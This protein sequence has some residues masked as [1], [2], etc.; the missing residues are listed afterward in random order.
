[1]NLGKSRD[2]QPL[3]KHNR[4]IMKEQRLVHTFLTSGVEEDE[5]PR[6]HSIFLYI[7]IFSGIW[8]DSP[9]YRYNVIKL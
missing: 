6:V 3:S 5:V 2:R 9:T 7:P 8:R 1:M 4:N